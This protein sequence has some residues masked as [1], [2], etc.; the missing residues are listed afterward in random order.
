MAKRKKY[1]YDSQRVATCERRIREW[2]R[3]L[4]VA[5]RSVIWICEACNK[6][7]E[8]GD[9]KLED[10]LYY[11][12]PSGCTSGDYWTPESPP[13]LIVT[14]PACD[15]QARVLVTYTPD[16][17]KFY[18]LRNSFKDYGFVTNESRGR[19]PKIRGRK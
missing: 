5:K 17:E 16:Y 4:E 14:C 11:T 12:R 7:S 19:V 9:T 6:P 2:K 1:P 18:D 3:E 10:V 15:E 8:V 13:S